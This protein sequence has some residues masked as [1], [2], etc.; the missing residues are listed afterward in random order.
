MLGSKHLEAS[1]LLLLRYPNNRCFHIVMCID[2][3][4]FAV[5]MNLYALT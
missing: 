3:L 2:V 1:T 4:D 5:K